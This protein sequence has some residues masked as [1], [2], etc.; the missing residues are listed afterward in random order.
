MKS[1][2]GCVKA[3]TS[4]VGTHLH[5]ALEP[6]WRLETGFGP[7]LVLW[8]DKLRNVPLGAPQL[9][10]VVRD[11][12]DELVDVA[13]VRRVTGRRV[14]HVALWIHRAPQ[15]RVQLVVPAR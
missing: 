9:L 6:C 5:H 11:R 1:R 8:V 10:V 13:R 4:C 2:N 15:Q 7:I 12:E 3:A 14:V